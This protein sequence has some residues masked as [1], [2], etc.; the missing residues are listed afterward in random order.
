M[1]VDCIPFRMVA[2][3]A[4][5]CLR[6]VRAFGVGSFFSFVPSA[7]PSVERSL[8]A[9]LIRATCENGTISGLNGSEEPA[10]ERNDPTIRPSE[11][12]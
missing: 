7:F 8:V 4:G 12:S 1:W 11:R 2:T 10:R 9:T 3:L 6:I 5:S